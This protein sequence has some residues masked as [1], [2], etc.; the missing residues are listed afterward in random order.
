MVPGDAKDISQ[1]V[2]DLVYFQFI[3]SCPAGSNGSAPEGLAISTFGSIDLKLWYGYSMIGTIDSGVLSI[4]QANGFVDVAGSTD[5][6]FEVC[7]P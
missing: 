3:D 2:S 7:R 1:K 4:H 6:T 5:L